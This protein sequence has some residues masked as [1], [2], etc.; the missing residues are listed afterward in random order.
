MEHGNALLTSYKRIFT[1]DSPFCTCCQA[2]AGAGG[3]KKRITLSLHVARMNGGISSAALQ[4][5]LVLPACVRSVEDHGYTLA[6]GIKVH[7][8]AP[9]RAA[10]LLAFL[11][12]VC[13]WRWAM[14]IPSTPTATGGVSACDT[15]VQVDV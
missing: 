15:L 2:G 8:I 9:S 6:L 5:G 3:G 1:C 13:V 11:N 4:P 10:S 12:V 14:R 7:S